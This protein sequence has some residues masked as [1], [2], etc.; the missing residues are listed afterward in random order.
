VNAGV[1]AFKAACR[2]LF[3]QGDRSFAAG[4]HDPARAQ[5][6]A[7]R[8]ALSQVVGT[9]FGRAHGLRGN[10]TYGAFKSLVPV[11]DYDGIRPWIDLQAVST[12]PV[13]TRERVTVYEETSGSSG[14]RKLIPYTPALLADFSYCFSRW[15]SDLIRHGPRFETGRIFF[16]ISPL[17]RERIRT[18]TGVPVGFPDDT[19]YLSPILRRLFGPLWIET[20]ELHTESDPHRCRIALATRLLMESRL[21]VVSI[22]S[23]T[24]LLSLLSLVEREREAVLSGLR[25]GWVEPQGTAQRLRLLEQASID[26]Q[27]VW[28]ELKLISCWSDASSGVPAEALRNLFPRALLQGKGLLSTEAA[29]TIPLLAAPAPVPLVN[30][31][32]LE[33]ERP[34]GEIVTLCEL[35]EGEQVGLIVSQ[36]GGLL[37]YRTH[38]RVVVAGRWGR[39]PCLRFLG[40]DNLL[41][42]LVGEKLDERFVR[43]ALAHAYERST[44]C[45]FLVPAAADAGAPGYVCITDNQQDSPGPLERELLAG[46][47]YQQARLLGQLHPITIRYVPDARERFEQ[48]FLRRGLTWGD[49][50]FAA[51]IPGVCTGELRRLVGPMGGARSHG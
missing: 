34:S 37:R 14:G 4:L 21:E 2:V 49:I 28:P 43:Q 31:V 50:K 17:F 32:F 7:L 8:R 20:P 40:R 48:L 35:E 45:R 42:D 5:A 36:T 16:G 18:P 24:Y 6:S 9:E 30:R 3:S 13:L 41:S 1:V 25:W 26:W 44:A 22:W 10:E 11:R 27:Q 33:C 47:Q 12:G 23:P 51:L 46:F 39:A 19:A 29:V 38:D 15:A